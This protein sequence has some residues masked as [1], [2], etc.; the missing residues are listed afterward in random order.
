MGLR[1]STQ[2]GNWGVCIYSFEHI[3]E[4]PFTTFGDYDYLWSYLPPISTFPRCHFA[5]D[6]HIFLVRYTS[7]PSVVICLDWLLLTSW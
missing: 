5:S 2:L 3:S 7:F 4:W 6:F 1:L